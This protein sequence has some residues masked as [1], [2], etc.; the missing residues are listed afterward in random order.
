MA[1]GTYDRVLLLV[2]RLSNKVIF[3]EWDQEKK[4][5]HMGRPLDHKQPNKKSFI[6]TR[7]KLGTY[8]G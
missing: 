1:H 3:G 6:T 5:Q 8:S 2:F 4:N 7:P